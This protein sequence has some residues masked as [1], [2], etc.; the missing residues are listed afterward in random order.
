METVISTHATSQK[1]R[2][3][4]LVP[5]GIVL[6]FL[7]TLCVFFTSV[8]LY[9]KEEKT[10]LPKPAPIPTYAPARQ[11]VATGEYPVGVI[12]IVFRETALTTNM[13]QAT[14]DMNTVKGPANES[15][16]KDDH[17][18]KGSSSPVTQE[19]Y[20]KLY[21]NGIVWP[22]ILMMPDETTFYQDPHFYGYY[23]EYDYWENPIGW[24]TEKEGAERV[25]KMNKAAL[26]FAEK[27]FRGS[28]PKVTCYNYITTRPAATDPQVTV[29]L[30]SFYQNRGADPDRVKAVRT[31]KTRKKQNQTTHQIDPW[32]YYAPV[33]KWGEPMWPNSKVQ[34]QDSAGGT[35]AHELGHCLGAPDVYRV[36]RF[37][38]GISGNACL[39]AY[40]P[41]ANAFSRFYHH[42]FIKEKNDPTLKS[43][44]SY[45]LYPRHIDP[46]DSQAIGYMIPTNHPHYFYHVEYI[47]NENSTVGV[48]PSHEGM[49]ISVVNLGRTNYLGSPD[50]FY[51]YR[52]NDPFFLGLGNVDQCLFG[53]SHKRTEFN[54]NTEPSSRLPNLLD[55]GVSFKNI[56]EHQG[57]LTF[58]LEIKHHPVTGS[59]YTLSMLPQIRLDDIT[60]VRPSS[61]TMN[62]TIKFR[63]EP[64]ITSYGFCWST[65]KMPTV[66]DSTFT[67]CHREWYRGHAIDLK[68]ETTYYVRAF[69]TNGLGYRYSDEEKMI[70]TPGYSSAP[71]T[72][73]PLLTDSFSHN[74]YLFT[75][76]SN[77]TTETSETFIGYSPTC[78][79]AKLIAYY[80]PARFLSAAEAGAKPNP[81]DFNRLSWRPGGDD[82]PARLDEID[83]FFQSV[84][85]QSRA[86][87]LHNPEPVAKASKK[88]V[89]QSHALGL[90]NSELGKDFLSNFVK[91]TGAHSKPVFHSITEENLIS[92]SDL[93]RKDLLLSH[94][95]M[96]VFSFD[97]ESVPEPSRWALIDG[98]DERGRFHIDFPQNTKFLL[99]RDTVEIKSGNIPAEALILPNYKTHVFTSI[100]L[101]KH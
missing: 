79:L 53:K 60:D 49:L 50:Y 93:I 19:E 37:N 30:L 51:V 39:L 87:G 71:S 7:L 74:N 28:R 99:D 24:P 56:E 17:G 25:E 22:K 10:A 14:A 21:S 3:G 20:F 83:G 35:L 95:V 98:I 4:F 85:D 80:R 15:G 5:S 47:H 97:S 89:N 18:N 86:L 68:P 23:C 36:G 84:Y 6:S 100:N 67:L 27:N 43:S 101:S 8:T 69:A 31:R 38:D 12:T 55:G 34:I 62:A 66:R 65:S 26:R 82:N 88:P 48:G 46:K 63:G 44:G 57:T 52:P 13:A 94:P 59:E 9:A 41:T 58:D 96:V 33:C 72:L 2:R 90:H 32:T 92:V 70:K 11:P 81:V 78:V 29:E 42:A 1:A 77:E 75:R 54:F 73:G 61:F 76:Y 64:I 45:T 16:S 91:L 40:G